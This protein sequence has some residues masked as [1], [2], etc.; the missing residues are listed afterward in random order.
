MEP[1]DK[2]RVQ[3][4]QTIAA[5]ES[6]RRTLRERFSNAMFIV[7]CFDTESEI[8]NKVLTKDDVIILMDNYYIYESRCKG[9]PLTL[10]VEYEDK[11]IV[12]KREGES[13][14]YYVDAIDELIRN[15]FVRNDCNHKFLERIIEIPHSKRCN[16]SIKTFSMCWG[17]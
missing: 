14:I 7:S 6:F 11:F 17:S 12:R 15:G 5:M 2:F 3:S 10:K 4:E 9:A 16:S 8:E 13:C 1:V